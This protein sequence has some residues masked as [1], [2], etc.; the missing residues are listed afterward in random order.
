MCSTLQRKLD[1]A[2]E[3]A[4]RRLQNYEQILSSKEA[5]SQDMESFLLWLQE[6]QVTVATNPAVGFSV[7]KAQDALHQHNVC[8]L[9]NGQET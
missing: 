7:Q 8:T 9:S 3:R 2:M 6:A 1:D 4:Q 5:V